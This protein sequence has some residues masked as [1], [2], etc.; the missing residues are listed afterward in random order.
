[1]FE[2]FHDGISL[3]DLSSWNQAEERTRKLLKV[4][5]KKAFLN[6]LQRQVHDTI[7]NMIFGDMGHFPMSIDSHEDLKMVIKSWQALGLSVS[8]GGVVKS[9]I[10][11]LK[12]R[13]KSPEH[14]MEVYARIAEILGP[15]AVRDPLLSKFMAYDESYWKRKYDRIALR[16][17]I[18][19]RANRKRRLV[20][21]RHTRDHRLARL[22]KVYYQFTCTACGR[23]QSKTLLVQISHKIPLRLG[24][25]NGGLDNP[26]NMETLCTECHERYEAMFDKEYEEKN[27]AE[28]KTWLASL[29]R[30]M[31]DY[32]DWANDVSVPECWGM[33]PSEVSSLNT[34]NGSRKKKRFLIF[35][36][37][38]RRRYRRPLIQ[39]PKCGGMMKRYHSKVKGK[40]GANT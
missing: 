29:Q 16:S 12:R 26:I 32:S 24:I 2:K 36:T 23:K 10:K 33:E 13:R 39:C 30:R 31:F 14:N 28:R 6:V 17:E 8:P 3:E 35:C 5:P 22:L 4:A 27:E 21:G 37:E 34:F 7:R 40:K 20:E 15:F 25:Q 1:L 38:C 11:H 9:V 19:E 18:I